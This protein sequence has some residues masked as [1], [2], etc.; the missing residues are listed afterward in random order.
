MAE[1]ENLGSEWALGG[2]ALMEKKTTLLFPKGMRNVPIGLDVFV[3]RC[4]GWS[5][6]LSALRKHVCIS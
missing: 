3:N 4:R 5:A 1:R 6:N 2:W